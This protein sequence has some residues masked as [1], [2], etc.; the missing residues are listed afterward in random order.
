MM[1]AG[2]GCM[3]QGGSASGP[4]GAL[5]PGSSTG[6]CR[7]AQTITCAKGDALYYSP[8]PGAGGAAGQGGQLSCRP[9]IPARDC[10]E[11]SLLR[12][13]GAGYKVLTMLVT[14]RYQS[15]YRE[16][17]YQS[18]SGGMALSL[19]GGVGGVMY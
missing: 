12:R 2:S 3:A 1:T 15:S 4:G 14:E 6:G 13:Y 19:D 8:A 17:S 11:R 9:Q 16:E 18:G 5:M 10:N 7:P